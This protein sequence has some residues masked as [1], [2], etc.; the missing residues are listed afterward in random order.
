MTTQKIFSKQAK[1][2]VII[3]YFCNALK[4]KQLTVWGH[5][6]FLCKTLL[7]FHCHQC[8]F[9]TSLTQTAISIDH[10]KKC[11]IISYS[12]GANFFHVELHSA[13]ILFNFAVKKR[14]K[15]FASTTKKWLD[16][17]SF[18][19]KVGKTL[20]YLCLC[21]ERCCLI[22]LYTQLGKLPG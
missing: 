3:I 14:R 5:F 18:Q 15:S 13:S 20:N 9:F 21:G 22:F 11:S 1:R 8:Q 6:F 17:F 2:L 19:L 12:R 16:N 10:G 7:F 4:C